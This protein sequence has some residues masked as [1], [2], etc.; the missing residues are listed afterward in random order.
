MSCDIQVP[1]PELNNSLY[2]QNSSELSNRDCWCG[3]VASEPQRTSHLIKFPYFWNQGRTSCTDSIFISLILSH[4]LF[5][6]TNNSLW[7][8]KDILISEEQDSET[9]E[10]QNFS[11]LILET[12]SCSLCFQRFNSRELTW[13][14]LCT[15]VHFSSKNVLWSIRSNERK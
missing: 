15:K 12:F 10:L 14:S 4:F 7:W 6:S 11:L 9:M 1:S 13:G 3:S 5:L 2:F 8:N